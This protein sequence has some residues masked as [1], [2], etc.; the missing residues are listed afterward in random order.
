[1]DSVSVSRWS[2]GAPW[3]CSIV[4][5]SPGFSLTVV[6]GQCQISHQGETQM[7]AVGD[8]IFAPLGADC[9]IYS[10]AR[11]PRIDLQQL[12]WQGYL[13]QTPMAPDGPSL[14]EFGTG[15]AKCRILGLAFTF[16][17]KGMGLLWQ[18]LPQLVVLKQPDTGL[19]DLLHP[20]MAYLA[21]QQGPGFSTLAK[22]LGSFVV[23]SLLNHYLTASKEP[24]IGWLRGLQD[25]AIAKALTAI[26]QQPEQPWSL[27]TLAKQ[28]GQSRASFAKH[29]L[30]TVGI[31]PIEY[32][33]R[34]RSHCAAEIL[35]TTSL[36]VA[37]IAEQVGFNSDRVFRTHF[38]KEYGQS[39][40]HWKKNMGLTTNAEGE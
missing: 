16:S 19:A 32:L 8:T 9:E 24:Q 20:A 4:D 33:N 12:P 35:A 26:H 2:L 5:F 17:S 38:Y 1:M 15:E 30:A 31:T 11:A 40:S 28:A 14:V 22:Q 13:Y 27:V 18:G 6:E 21:N 39:P 25:P 10:D 23:C 7:V 37:Q 3:G 29:F 36:S 34:W